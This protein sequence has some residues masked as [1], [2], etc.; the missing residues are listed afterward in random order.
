MVPQTTVLRQA[1]AALLASLVMLASLFALHHRV[2]HAAQSRGGRS[3]ALLGL[4]IVA[5]AI[6][7]LLALAL[8]SRGS[9]AEL[10]DVMS[11]LVRRPSWS[12]REARPAPTGDR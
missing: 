10:R 4:E 5:G 7:Y 3:F 11:F 12:R 8:L 9:L 2:A 1:Q 6:A